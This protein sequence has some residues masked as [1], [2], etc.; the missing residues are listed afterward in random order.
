[1]SL[2]DGF[3]SIYLKFDKSLIERVSD[4]FAFCKELLM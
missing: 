1:M 3:A 4:L 2:V